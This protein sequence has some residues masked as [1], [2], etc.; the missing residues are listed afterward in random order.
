MGSGR[1]WPP[2]PP[3]GAH[4]GP[5]NGVV[6]RPWSAQGAPLRGPPRLLLSPGFERLPDRARAWDDGHHVQP[7]CAAPPPRPAAVRRTLR[8]DSP[9][10]L[11]AQGEP[12][13]H[14]PRGG[15][16]IP[17]R[18]IPEATA[19]GEPSLPAH[20]EP[21]EDL[22]EIIPPILALPRGRARRPWRRWRIRL[23][24]RERHGGRVLMPPGRGAGRHL[25]SLQSHRAHPPPVRWAAN[26]ASRIGP[27]RL[28]WRA[29]RGNAACSSSTR[30]RAANRFPTL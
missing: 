10:S 22:V 29:A 17:A 15:H 25:Q 1:R 5:A 24:A 8:D 6:P 23:G 9:D 16:T 20:A 19:P 18:T 26:R 21:Q 13:R 30:P 14:R 2:L 27:Q 11:P 12:L 28:S 4:F 7:R 3:A